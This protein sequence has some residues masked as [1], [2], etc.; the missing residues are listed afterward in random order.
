MNVS[1]WPEVAS[2][3]PRYSPVPTSAFRQRG[4][5]PGISQDHVS[6][7]WYH[8]PTAEQ[9]G[10]LRY[11]YRE[12]VFLF[13]V[14]RGASLYAAF[15]QIVQMGPI[16]FS[17]QKSICPKFVPRRNQNSAEPHNLKLIGSVTYVVSNCRELPDFAQN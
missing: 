4:Q 7:C 14:G 10:N 15:A 1:F 9:N 12:P 8:R 6:I 3:N 13:F 2:N 5:C 11:R 16:G 17:W